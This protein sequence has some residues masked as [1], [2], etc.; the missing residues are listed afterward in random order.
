MSAAA[1]PFSQEAAQVIEAARSVAAAEP[2]ARHVAFVLFCQHPLGPRLAW[3]TGTTDVPSLR[4]DLQRCASLPAS[5]AEAQGL[6][7]DPELLVCRAQEVQGSTSVAAAAAAPQESPEAATEGDGGTCIGIGDLVLALFE[8][9][10]QLAPVMARNGL[11]VADVKAQLPKALKASRLYAAQ[12]ALPAGPPPPDLPTTRSSSSGGQSLRRGVSQAMRVLR[13]REAGTL[14]SSEQNDA[15]LAE[16]SP[17]SSAESAAAGKSDDG[18][19]PEMAELAPRSAKRAAERRPALASCA[20]ELVEVARKGRLDAVIG[21][22]DAIDRVLQVLARR[23]KSNV[24]LVGD[25]GVGKTAVVEGVAQRIAEGR[26]P[27]QLRSCRELW[28][29]DIGALL[30]GTGLR[31]DFEEKLREVMAEVRSAG[32]SL[33]LFIDELHLVLGA[34]RSENNNVDAANLLKPMLARGEIRCI[35]ATTTDEYRRLILA[36]DGAFE[37]RFQVLEIA[38]PSAAAAAEMLRGLLP[39][40][41]AHHGLRIDPE[42]AIVAVRA[43]Q[44]YIQ[45]RRLPDKAIDV[46]DEACAAAAAAGALELTPAA[47]EAS[48]ASLRASVPTWQRQR[49]WLRDALASLFRMSRL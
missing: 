14:E 38:E 22:N 36:K 8:P 45:G 46:L 49:Q 29:L 25:P 42:A 17:A 40:Y 11:K 18:L 37:R 43:S 12:A 39:A 31:G 7:D 10:L 24:C 41:A 48:A 5:H 1:V 9:D 33:V 4:M 19:P 13:A 34:G 15:T 35:G 3:A 26:V 27:P 28:S 32:T 47:V 23:T 44:R 2:S 6:R 20:T 16:P 21:R 30:A